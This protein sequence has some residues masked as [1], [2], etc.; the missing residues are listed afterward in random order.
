MLPHYAFICATTLDHK[1]IEML[2]TYSTLWPS[3]LHSL[4]VSMSKCWYSSTDFDLLQESLDLWAMIY[5][6]P[7]LGCRVFLSCYLTGMSTCKEHVKVLRRPRGLQ[8]DR[9][10]LEPYKAWLAPSPT[11]CFVN[12]DMFMISTGQL[13]NKKSALDELHY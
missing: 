4:G 2:T 5:H 13:P 12:G 6:S 11:L 10:K 7:L 8:Y 9:T 1:E 3:P